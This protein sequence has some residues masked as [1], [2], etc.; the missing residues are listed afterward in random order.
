MASGTW[1]ARPYSLRVRVPCGAKQAAEAVLRLINCEVP[2]AVEFVAA[3]TVTPEGLELEL[4][5]EDGRWI[6]DQVDDL[7]R[8]LADKGLPGR[9]SWK[10]G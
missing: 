1:V 3:A 9:D 6:E 4:L 2:D 7:E 10:V 5:L 8:S